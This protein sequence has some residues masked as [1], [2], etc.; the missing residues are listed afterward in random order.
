MRIRSRHDSFLTHLAK[1]RLSASDPIA[2]FAGS[3]IQ[4]R[5]STDFIRQQR[6]AVNVVC[7]L[8]IG[9]LALM[10]G[11]TLLDLALNFGWDMDTRVLWAAP[12][13]SA[14]AVALRFICFAIFNF[15]DSNY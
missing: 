12:L 9:F 7:V 1:S 5:M 13:M 10:W 3:G 15:V 14:F 2:D 6:N 8:F 11:A 4:S